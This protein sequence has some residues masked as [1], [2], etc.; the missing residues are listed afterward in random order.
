MSR[1]SPKRQQG[2]GLLVFVLIAT[3]IALS[4]VLGYSGLLTRQEALA[5]PAKI[6][7]YLS[8]AR[9]QIL[10]FYARNLSQIDSASVGSVTATDL[11]SGANVN[12]RYGM[13]AAL[14]NPLAG[15]SGLS[16][17]RMVLYLPTETDGTNPPDV[18]GFV[19]NGNFQS[20]ID[21]SKECA[22]RYYMVFDSLTLEKAALTET[23]HRLEQV[24]YK[25]QAYFKARMLLD[26][27]HNI[28]IDYFRPAFGGCS[29]GLND[30][31]CLDTYTPLAVM[32]S[33]S[34]SALTNVPSTIGLTNEE[35]ISAWGDPIQASNLTDSETGSPPFT[36]V[37][38]APSPFG[39][40]F[41]VKAVQQI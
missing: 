9:S 7:A 24:A 39:G 19:A 22:T 28:S 41:T 35:L 37:F 10:S 27:E 6:Q 8:D 38:R 32:S 30:L 26:P 20:C 18:A 31:Q 14:S 34:W 2:F 12:V 36:M 17:R 13:Q 21:S 33:G 25:A 29:P 11:L 40:Y 23:K 4:L 1:L 16:Y 5:R 15:D 3:T